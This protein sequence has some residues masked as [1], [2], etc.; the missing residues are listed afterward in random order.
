M[1]AKSFLGELEQMVLLAIV[2]GRNDASGIEISGELERRAERAVSKGSLYTTLDRLK[3]KGLLEWRIDP[4]DIAR[5]GLPRRHF[6]VTEAG[7]V[8]LRESRTALLNLWEGSE[9]ILG[10]AG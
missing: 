3:K 2:A 7:V 5:S 1:A 8:A 9:D 6:T 10:E 4:G